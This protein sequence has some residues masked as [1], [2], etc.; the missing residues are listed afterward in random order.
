MFKVRRQTTQKVAFLTFYFKHYLM[1][2]SLLLARVSSSEWLQHPMNLLF[3]YGISITD[4]SNEIR[5]IWQVTLIGRQTDVRRS[6]LEQNLRTSVKFCVQC[7]IKFNCNVHQYSLDGNI[8]AESSPFLPE[9]IFC[10]G[11]H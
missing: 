4:I 5:E 9:I 10:E 1:H 2:L 7:R 6:L 8:S 11:L 3:Y